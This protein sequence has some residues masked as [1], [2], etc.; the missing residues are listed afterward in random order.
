MNC[1]EKQLKQRKRDGI[2]NAMSELEKLN[3]HLRPDLVCA[4]VARMTCEKVTSKN[5]TVKD[6]AGN[7]K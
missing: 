2:K 5:I 3:S 6:D 7:T 4:K 1:E